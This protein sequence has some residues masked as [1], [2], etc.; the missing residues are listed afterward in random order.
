M[1]P[2]PKD[3]APQLSAKLLTD[4]A[5]TFQGSEEVKLNFK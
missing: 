3:K 5:Q 4:M 1:L 2:T